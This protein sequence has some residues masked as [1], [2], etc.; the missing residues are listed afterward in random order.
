MV[1]RIASVSCN[2]M[3]YKHKHNFVHCPK[4]SP[5]SPSINHRAPDPGPVLSSLTTPCFFVH[6]L[7]LGPDLAALRSA[8]PS[9]GSRARPTSLFAPLTFSGFACFP[10]SLDSSSDAANS[11]SGV[12]LLGSYAD[13]CWATSLSV[14]ESVPSLRSGWSEVRSSGLLSLLSIETGRVVW[15]RRRVVVDGSWSWSDRLVAVDE[16]FF[17]IV[18]D[19][20]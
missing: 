2:G 18:G 12:V 4:P 3:L 17:S 6:P 9:F 19:I 20:L 10:S 15:R 8:P 14:P 11:L 5:A 13:R 1:A 16:R 7:E